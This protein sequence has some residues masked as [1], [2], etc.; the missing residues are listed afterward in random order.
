[1][2]REF[3][4]IGRGLSHSFSAR[5]FNCKFEAEGLDASYALFDIDKISSLADLLSRTH[6][7]G[8]NV[9]SPYKREVIPF[10][11][12]LSDEAEALNAVNV[13]EFIHDDRRRLILKGHNTD[14]EGFN[15]TLN[16]LP[17]VKGALI[18][19]TGGAS[20][21]VALAL[22]KRGI[23]HKVVSRTPSEDQIGYDEANSLIPSHNLIVNATPLG[24][25][26]HIDSSPGIDYESLSHSHICYDLIYNPEET[27]FMKLSKDNGARTF[28]G[29]QMLKNQAELAWKIWNRNERQDS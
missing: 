12:L 4:L 2:H 9:T 3:G 13:I 19:G 29:L 24:M 18:L 28:N 17:P 16:V 5:Y 8:L 7:S 27:L 23:Q 15:L 14:W 21:A 26:P 11:D 22:A 25:F 1:M 20:S 10:L 6:I